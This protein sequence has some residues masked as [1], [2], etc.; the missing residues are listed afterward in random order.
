MLVGLGG[1]GDVAK[2]RLR[3]GKGSGRKWFG[4]VGCLTQDTSRASRRMYGSEGLDS[5]RPTKEEL[6]I[7]REVRCARFLDPLRLSCFLANQP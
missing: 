4:D 1:S 5:L 3:I 6:L 7:S 2:E